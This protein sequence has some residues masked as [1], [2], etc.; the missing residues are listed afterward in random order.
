MPVAIATL[1]V[2]KPS[3][4]T[5]TTASRKPGMASSVSTQPPDHRVD[6]AAEKA[7]QQ[8]EQAAREQADADRH[9]RRCR[10]EERAP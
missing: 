6:P 3:Q 1:I 4:V 2:L 7:G 9:Q 10:T 8:A 5:S